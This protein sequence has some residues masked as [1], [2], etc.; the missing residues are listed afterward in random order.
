MLPVLFFQKRKIL[1]SSGSADITHSRQF[2]DVECAIFVRGI[3]PVKTWG[4]VILGGLGSA[5][6]G[7]L[8][9]GVPHP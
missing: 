3:V 5:Y 8:G 2:A 9:L 7:S 6:L 4:N 1:I